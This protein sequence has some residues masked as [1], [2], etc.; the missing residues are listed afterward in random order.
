MLNE[1][2]AFYDTVSDVQKRAN[3]YKAHIVIPKE[4]ETTS[5]AVYNTLRILNAALIESAI[6]F[7]VEPTIPENEPVQEDKTASDVYG[8]ILRAHEKL[9]Q[10]LKDVSYEK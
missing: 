5:D 4:K 6:Y 3:M 2:L 1:A 9:K 7:G 10:L 8:L